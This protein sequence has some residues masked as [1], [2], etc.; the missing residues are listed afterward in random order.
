MSKQQNS[1]PT[2]KE[3]ADKKRTRAATVALSSKIEQAG[4]TERRSKLAQILLTD[5]TIPFREAYKKAGYSLTPKSRP[6]VIKREIA[7]ALSATLREMG[8]FESDL[9]KVLMECLTA[10]KATLVKVPVYFENGI[11]KTNRYESIEV[12]DYPVRLAAFKQACL[13]GDYFPAKKI[14]LKTEHT[15]RLFANIELRT[16]EGRAKEL[17]EKQTLIEVEH[18]VVSNDS[19]D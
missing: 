17:R 16:L 3:L 19:D 2:P 10:T 1:V 18:E 15:E 6:S 9:A 8:I 5:P 14:N 7:G 12:P 13:L 11:L 4:L